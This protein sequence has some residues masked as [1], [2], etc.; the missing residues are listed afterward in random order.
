MILLRADMVI[1]VNDTQ[2]QNSL[3]SVVFFHTNFLESSGFM[4][5]YSLVPFSTL[6][7]LLVVLVIKFLLASHNSF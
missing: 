7:E 3:K 2:L 4:L 5:Q 1:V 6:Y